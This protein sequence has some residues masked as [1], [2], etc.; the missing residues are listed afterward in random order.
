MAFLYFDKCTCTNKQNT[1]VVNK[2]LYNL[3]KQNI[4]QTAN[5]TAK[6]MFYAF[7]STTT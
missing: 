5:L 3:L 2:E 7:W 4:N 6:F 1:E